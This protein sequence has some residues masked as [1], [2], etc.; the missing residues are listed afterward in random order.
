[1]TKANPAHEGQGGKAIAKRSTDR[2]SGAHG[3]GQKNMS[4][5]FSPTSH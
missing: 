4:S 5:L 1:M 3:P 2:I